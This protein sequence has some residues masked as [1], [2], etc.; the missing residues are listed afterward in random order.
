MTRFGGGQG[1]DWGGRYKSN[2]KDCP[3]V[4]GSE[5]RAFAEQNGFKVKNE[6]LY[7]SG[8]MWLVIINKIWYTLGQ[9][10]YL[11]LSRL[12]YMVSERTK[13]RNDG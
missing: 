1:R 8:G 2:P 9:T 7:G 13:E 10:N 5:V 6:G 3:K 12:E 4:S 11:A